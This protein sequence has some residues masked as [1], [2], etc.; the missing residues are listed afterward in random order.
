MK[1]ILL[2]IL[3]VY[4]ISSSF[5]QTSLPDKKIPLNLDEL[6][7][8]PFVSDPAISSDGNYA[9]YTIKN[10]PKGSNTLV[11]L[12]TKNSWRQE[13]SLRQSWF[14][15]FFSGTNKQVIF[16]ND[17][18][19]SFLPLDKGKPQI[20]PGITSFKTPEKG[21]KK[22]LAY[23]I[24]NPSKE[25][26]LRNLLNGKEQ[27]FK[28]IDDYSFNE[29]GNTLI[30]KSDVNR[31]TLQW[32]NLSQD[33]VH[34]IW[35]CDSSKIIDYN[36]DVKGKQIVFTEQ[37][38]MRNSYVNAIWYYR[39]G[40]EAAELRVN[41][42]SEEM[43]EGLTVGG[44]PSFSKNG[45]WIFLN[46]R[47][48]KSK[49]S[50]SKSRTGV[51]VWSYKDKILQPDQEVRYQRELIPT[52][53]AVL[54]SIG[55]RLIR[56]QKDDETASTSPGVITGDHIV[57][58][59]TYYSAQN[60]WSDNNKFLYFLV[61]LKDGSRRLIQKG[62]F[63]YNFSFSPTGK[64]LI[65]YDKS[66][67]HY[68]SYN[69]ETGLA[70]N[71]TQEISTSFKDEIQNNE[72]TQGAV[73][74]IGGWIGIER[75]LILYDNY[76]I[77][78][79]D[80]NGIITP[81]N[82]TNAYGLKNHVKLRIVNEKS[83]YNENE[84][85]LIT[86]FNSYNK[87]GGFYK[88]SLGKSNF[89]KQL[90]TGPYTYYRVAS[91]KPHFYSFDD[92]M[93]PIKAVKTNV[94]LVQRGSATE[95][96]NYFVTRDFRN[97][98]A[99]SKLQPELNCNWLTTELITWTQLDGT[100]SQ[101]ILYKPEDFDCDKKYPLIL[102]YYQ[103]LS[104]RLNEYPRPG[105][106][107]ANINIPWFV[108]HGYL[109]FTPD[110]WYHT[111]TTEHP[112]ES[113]GESA[114]NSVVSSALNLGKLPFVDI[115]KIGLDG[116]SFGGLETNYIVTHTRM[117][118]AVA[119]AA[120]ITD[121]ISAEFTLAPFRSSIE[122]DESGDRRFVQC[123]GGANPWEHPEIFQKNSAI[124]NAN[125][126][127]SPILIMHN[128]KDNQIQWRQGIEFY[129]ALRRLGKKTWMLQYDNGDHGVNGDDAKDYT[130]RLTQFFDHYLKDK[131]APVWMTRG[132]PFSKKGIETGYEMDTTGA[133]P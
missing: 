16:F 42:Q 110:I 74:P 45:K 66:Q 93:K 79:F 56:I 85:L 73:A 77:W 123:A 59:D 24:N 17:D 67:A 20:I 27:R 54:P 133:I 63:L 6:E 43:K 3:Y 129:M 108:S 89:I 97:F 104:H 80:P 128:Q 2:I 130:I 83:S 5:G 100:T 115:K 15:V 96:P 58:A 9:L 7:K 92:G 55:G 71:L 72:N 28:G 75:L 126:V 18:T 86:G 64:Y 76:D 38:K 120:G 52:Y 113:N 118:A 12:S 105:L 25:L 121:P 10:Q 132:V 47:A 50:F 82:I 31:A 30:M 107:G 33:I 131:P 91:Q 106:T 29:Q 36:F 41:N 19:L 61:S 51:N 13:I 40:M 127:N 95:T 57:I 11:I 48:S 109:V 65:F 111:G 101:G 39:E 78:T 35:S 62:N 53:L 90:T 46:L 102:N 99:L 88:F 124:L 21:I 8:W 114:Y 103:K 125:K 4:S 87:N 84:S 23:Q 117:F 122:H 70:R 81:K 60:W 37:K 69:T 68:F 98:K 94:W 119:T 14:T 112:G 49:A 32:L 34:T 44:S 26:I 116:H 22:W 1:N